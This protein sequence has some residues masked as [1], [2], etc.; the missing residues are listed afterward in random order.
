MNNPYTFT[1][2]DLLLI[3]Q[4]FSN[5]HKDWAK[6]VFDGMKGKIKKELLIMQNKR[7]VYCKSKLRA[8]TT[9]IPIEHVVPKSKHPLFT[10]EATNLVLSC[11]MCNTKKS[12]TE[13]LTDPKV[14]I[15]PTQSDGFL[16]I[17]PYV[18]NYDDHLEIIDGIFICAKSTKGENTVEICKL[19]RLELAIGKAEDLYINQADAYT[20]LMHRLINTYDT[21]LQIRIN[22]I[23]N[24]IDQLVFE[25][26]V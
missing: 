25:E 22:E 10:F 21:T 8:E 16:I 9:A 23:I 13:T 19:D 24:I 18:D 26:A 20:K 6:R 1:A 12:I 17:N 3:S 2:A 15:Y 4:H 7:C 11:P 5:D 14:I